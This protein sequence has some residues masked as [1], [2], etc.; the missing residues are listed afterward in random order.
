MNRQE[1]RKQGITGKAKTYVL[2]SDQIEQLKKEATE[3]AIGTAF[4]LMLGLPVMILHDKYSQIMKKEVD[5]KCREERFAEM[6]LDLYDS[7]DKGYL[8]LDD[9]RNCV[10]EETGMKLLQK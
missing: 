4:T 8:T 2:N 7:F 3:E 9:I 6:I 10:E 5:G 1:R